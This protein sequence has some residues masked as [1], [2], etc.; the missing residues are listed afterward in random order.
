MST[1]R[2]D[3]GIVKRLLDNNITVEVCLT[4]NIG[5]GFKVENY[6]VHPVR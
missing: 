5:N 6:S 4:S 2:S 3:E 1:V